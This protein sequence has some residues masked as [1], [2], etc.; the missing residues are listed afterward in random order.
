MCAYDDAV[1]IYAI[2]Q[3]MRSLLKPKDGPTLTEIVYVLYILWAFSK[4][5]LNCVARQ[6]IVSENPHILKLEKGYHFPYPYPF[7]AGKRVWGPPVSA[8]GYDI[9]SHLP[10][11]FFI[12]VEL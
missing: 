8:N 6:Y 3:K 12:L 2:A 5:H 4:L 11:H 10:A 9:R 7:I 1:I